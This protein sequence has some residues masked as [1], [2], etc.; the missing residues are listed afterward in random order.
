MS[1]QSNRIV[2]LLNIG[3]E[4]K[5]LSTPGYHEK[6]LIERKLEEAG[7]KILRSVVW[8][9]E[10]EPTLVVRCT[11][12]PS[13]REIVGLCRTLCQDCI[14]VFDVELQEGRLVGPQAYKWGPF[15]PHY[16]I[17]LD[18]ARLDERLYEEGE[19]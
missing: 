10:T 2:A 4:Y 6:E 7:V 9:S 13:F 19:A 12:D 3:M 11:M 16:F 1:N 8:E 17:C 5:T 15:D 14:A 18:G